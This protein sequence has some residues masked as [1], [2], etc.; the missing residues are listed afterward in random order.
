MSFFARRRPAP[1]LDLARAAAELGWRPRADVP[2]GRHVLDLIHETS[3]TMYGAARS[4]GYSGRVDDTRYT[5][6]YETTDAGRTVVVANAHTLIDPGLFQGGRSTPAV[7]VCA[8]E[9]PVL[10]PR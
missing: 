6:V 4:L 5:D 2:F 3:R 8:V 9:V 7:A 1:A 10:M